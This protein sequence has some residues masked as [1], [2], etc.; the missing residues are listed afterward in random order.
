MSLEKFHS[1]PMRDPT[2]GSFHVNAPSASFHT[3]AP[4]RSTAYGSRF[5]QSYPEEPKF[6][7]NPARFE[8]HIARD[9]HSLDGTM[10]KVRLL[11]LDD[12]GFA[13]TYLRYVQNPGLNM[14]DEISIR[15]D[16]ATNQKKITLDGEDMAAHFFTTYDNDEKLAW[17]EATH[18]NLTQAERD[19][20]AT[21]GDVLFIDLSPFL[22]YGRDP[23]NALLITDM[24]K[25]LVLDIKLKP[26]SEWV[27]TDDPALQ[28]KTTDANGTYI[29][30]ETFATFTQHSQGVLDNIRN[31]IASGSGYTFPYRDFQ[32]T[33][34][35]INAADAA[36]PFWDVDL[37][38][39]ASQ[40]M[41]FVTYM[42]YEDE[43][44]IDNLL[45][46][47]RREFRDSNMAL[48]APCD[49]DLQVRLL[50]KH[51]LPSTGDLNVD[52]IDLTYTGVLSNPN[53]F[54]GSKGN[55]W[56]KPRIRIYPHA[57][58]VQEMVDNNRNVRIRCTA[59][60]NNKVTYHKNNKQRALD[61][62]KLYYP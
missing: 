53:V 55:E 37:E 5:F 62:A 42:T 3:P 27:E 20:Q 1:A 24:N 15:Q 54:G 58:V 4:L 40:N 26:I 45:P 6:A 50:N 17:D 51:L 8:V 10:L 9:G 13:G 19:V 18:G 32:T 21:T 57:D 38:P 23:S 28:I 36:R 39:F 43:K 47:D 35:I 61:F 30:L 14:F 33:D 41:A 48:I 44:G 29:E 22:F 59:L 46:W 12:T 31:V 16:K 7:N 2:I 49:Y 56:N 34:T 60:I 52:I 11:P 25:D